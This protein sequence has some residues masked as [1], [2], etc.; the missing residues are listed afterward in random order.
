MLRAFAEVGNKMGTARRCNL[1]KLF[2]TLQSRQLRVDD[3]VKSNPE[4]FQILIR[5]SEPVLFH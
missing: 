2:F 4:G 1:A 5:V 3:L